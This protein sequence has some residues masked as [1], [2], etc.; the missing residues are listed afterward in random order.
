M[1]RAVPP[2]IE[3]KRVA[4]VKISN[5]WYNINNCVGGGSAAISVII[6]INGKTNFLHSDWA[7][8]FLAAVAAVLTYLLTTFHA[9]KK[10]AAF[11]LASREVE[12]AIVRYST[13]PSLP[14]SFLGESV[15][16]GIEILNKNGAV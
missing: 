9:D 5:N 4:W 13:D 16:R 15:A 1:P 6:A 10:G 7:T 11:M 14:E 2:E 3:S 8:T 12:A